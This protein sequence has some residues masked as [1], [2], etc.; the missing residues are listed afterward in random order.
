[1]TGTG[2]TL[3]CSC[4]SLCATVRL[5]DAGWHWGGLLD[6]FRISGVPAALGSAGDLD[7]PSRSLS[8]SCH[9]STVMTGFLTFAGWFAFFERISVFDSLDKGVL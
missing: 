1:M 5:S 7:P 4:F 2:S 8:Q 9:P 3:S 6:F